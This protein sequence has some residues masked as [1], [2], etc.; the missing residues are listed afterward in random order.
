MFFGLI[1]TDKPNKTIVYDSFN[2]ADNALTLGN[3][4]TGQ[5]WTAVKGTWGISGN[6]AAVIVSNT[7]G[8]RANLALIESGIC[9][10]IIEVTVP[11]N[12]TVPKLIFR[13]LD[14]SNEWMLYNTSA[15]NTYQLSKRV[16][17]TLT[18]QADTGVLPVNGDIIKIMYKG[19]TIMVY[20]NGV[21][22]ASVIDTDLMNDTKCGLGN[23]SGIST[24][25]DNFKLEAI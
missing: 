19:S 6:L 18:Q 7:E 9:D 2:R 20:I 3:A 14:E 1:G 17:G 15:S 24:R 25:W 5:A 8:T 4:D 23:T 22:R 12:Q 21:L 13:H 11:G 16:A 10:G